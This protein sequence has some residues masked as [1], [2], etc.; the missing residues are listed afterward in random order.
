MVSTIFI[1]LVFTFIFSP[2]TRKA[3]SI[4]SPIISLV[5]NF[6]SLFN[7]KKYT[8]SEVED[9]LEQAAK[10]YFKDYPADLP[11]GNGDIV[12]IITSEN[13]KGLRKARNS[14]SILRRC[15]LLPTGFST[16]SLKRQALF[17]F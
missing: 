7:T 6:A 4:E 1:S 14:T 13:S 10:D 8:Y 15:F 9:I 17:Y 5:E 12:E 11:K 16:E 2:N 3:I